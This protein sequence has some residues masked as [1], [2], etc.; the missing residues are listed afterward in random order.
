MVNCMPP[1]LPPHP[2]EKNSSAHRTEG[3]MDPGA[4]LDV[5]EKR[6]ITCPCWDLNLKPTVPA[7]LPFLQIFT[8]SP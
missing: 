4:D 2:Q 7:M 6:K 1:K 8:F 3:W 5:L